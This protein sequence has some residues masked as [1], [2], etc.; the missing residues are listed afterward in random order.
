MW[1][2]LANQWLE[3]TRSWLDQSRLDFD[4]TRKKFWWLWRYSGS[5]SLWLSLD[6]DSTK[7]SRAHHCRSICHAFIVQ[8][9]LWVRFNRCENQEWLHVF[10]SVHVITKKQG[11]WTDLLL[12]IISMHLCKS[13]RDKTYVSLYLFFMKWKELTFACEDARR[14]RML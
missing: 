10:N 2:E 5:T 3:V 13:F 8:D 12:Y 4:C 6:S 7:L 14:Q 1:L 9:P 11:K